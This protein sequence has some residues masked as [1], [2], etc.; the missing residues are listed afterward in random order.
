[1]KKLCFAAAVISV[2]AA[3][4][5]ASDSK[6]KYAKNVSAAPNGDVVIAGVKAPEYFKD[7]EFVGTGL[8]I[9]LS[10]ADASFD[11]AP[12]AKILKGEKAIASIMAEVNKYLG[13]T[14]ISLQKLKFS[15][16]AFMREIDGGFPVLCWM[17]SSSAYDGALKDRA[18]KRK[19]TADIGAWKK[20]LRKLELKN[21]PKENI[22]TQAVVAGYDKATGEFLVVGMKT[23]ELWLTASE[24]KDA[25]FEA[26]TLRD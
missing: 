12:L 14:K 6:G 10:Y 21:M 11:F 23:P 15:G 13:K 22:H 3:L 16:N 8:L 24:L 2:C 17:Y 19:A 26:Y 4:F 5:A 9:L 1:M 25:V 18:A 20:E 7:S